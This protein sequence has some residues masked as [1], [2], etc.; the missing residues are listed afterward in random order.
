M[1]IELHVIL[2]F[3]FG[4]GVVL[5]V[6]NGHAVVGMLSSVEV[7]GPASEPRQPS[8]WTVYDDVCWFKILG[9]NGFDKIHV[10]LVSVCLLL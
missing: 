2:I 3:S 1:L 10:S 6:E 4:N 5:T 7:L 8:E 9:T